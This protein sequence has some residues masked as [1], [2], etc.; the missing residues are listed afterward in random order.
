MPLQNIEFRPG[1]NKENATHANEGGWSHSNFVRF[2]KGYPEPVGGWTLYTDNTFLGVCRKIFNWTKLNGQNCTALGTNLKFYQELGG[3][4]FDITPLRK[5]V[6]PMSTDPFTT[7]AAASTTITVSDTAHGAAVGD[8]VT[9]SGVVGPI[10][11]IPAADFNQEHTVA[12][13]IDADSYTIE[14]DTG[15]SAGSVSGG[16]AACVA[17]YQLNIGNDIA[18]PTTGWGAGEWSSGTWGSSG[19]DFFRDLIRMWSVSTF[20]EDLIAC[21]R[22]GAIYYFDASVAPAARM[23]SLAD[24][25][26]ANDAPVDCLYAFV[27]EQRFVVALGCDP[28]GGDVTPD[29]LLVRWSNQENAVDWSQSVVN[30]AGDYRLALGSQIMCGFPM[31]GTNLIFT[32]SAV[33]SM[34][35]IGFPNVFGFELLADQS[36]LVS[37]NAVGVIGNLA[38]WMGKGRFYVYDGQVQVLPCDVKNYVFDDINW[39]QSYQIY[40]FTTIKFSEIT[41]YY[42]S[43]GTGVNPNTTIDRWVT[44]N[45]E[46]KV[47]SCGY[48]EN[49][50]QQRTARCDV[51]VRD[52]PLAVDYSGQ[53]WSHEFGQ[54]QGTNGIGVNSFIQ[55]YPFNIGQVGDRFQFVSKVLPDILFDGSEA[56]GTSTSVDITLYPLPYDSAVYGNWSNPLNGAKGTTFTAMA[57]NPRSALTPGI[58]GSSSGLDA[59]SPT[60]VNTRIR[61]R[62]IIM[63]LDSSQA[64]VRWRLGRLRLDVR[65]DGRKE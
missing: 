3:D 64:G 6:D 46:D 62:S 54:D 16:G 44:F 26:N 48:F 31:R 60:F 4:L 38:F 9:F 28:A 39:D 15:C 24:R 34:Q 65:P 12:T 17:E 29:P 10:D 21:V 49:A 52:Y 40:A 41:W 33:Y 45:Y 37:P 7:G 42:C 57:Y 43:M 1:I 53:I 51:Y 30:T 19:T 5:T 32:D 50:G 35:Y 61:G 36:F 47:W 8:Y 11:G 58:S 18:S 55:S 13:V 22:G 23:E 63:R 14:V 2:R 56:T 20:G 59:L 27:T 25:P